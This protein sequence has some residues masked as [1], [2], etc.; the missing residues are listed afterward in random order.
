MWPLPIDNIDPRPFESLPSSV[1]V[2]LAL[3]LTGRRDA[4]QI[5]IEDVANDAQVRVIHECEAVSERLGCRGLKHLRQSQPGVGRQFWTIIYHE[6]NVTED[7]EELKRLLTMT[8]ADSME[9]AATRFHDEGIRTTRSGVV[10]ALR[11]KNFQEAKYGL[12]G[13]ILGLS[14]EADDFLT[15]STF[16]CRVMIKCSSFPQEFGF[17]LKAQMCTGQFNTLKSIEATTKDVFRFKPVVQRM[18]YFIQLTVAPIMKL[19]SEVPRS[20]DPEEFRPRYYDSAKRH[21]PL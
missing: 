5:D 16:R 6:S 8:G 2:N 21:R 20:S 3:L 18:G 1:G 7:I 11:V 12:I 15:D 9:V 10:P 13:R 14:C 17:V 19:Y 4:F